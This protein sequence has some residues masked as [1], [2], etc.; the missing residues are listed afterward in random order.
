MDK[1]EGVGMSLFFVYWEEKQFDNNK[2]ETEGLLY[3]LTWTQEIKN[4]ETTIRWWTREKERRSWY[5]IQ[6]PIHER[7]YACVY[8]NNEVTIQIFGFLLY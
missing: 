3:E 2:K 7:E 8:H 6:V 4:M 5:N 1:I